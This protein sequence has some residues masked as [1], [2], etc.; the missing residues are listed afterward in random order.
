MKIAIVL[1]TSW[2]IYNFRKGLIKNFLEQGHEVVAIAPKDQFS[3][4][5]RELP[6]QFIPIRMDSRGIN[7]LKDIGL[8]FELLWI[9]YRHA[10]D[11]ILHYTIKPN[12]FGSIAAGLLGIKNVANV[13]GLGTLFLNPGLPTSFAMWLY[14]LAFRFPF[15]VFFQNAEDQNVFVSKNLI[16]ESRCRQIPGSG[17]DVDFFR[18]F[19]KTIQ[20]EVHFLMM[21]R[22]ILDKGVKEFLSAARSLKDKGYN[23]RFSL[24]GKLDPYHKRGIPMAKFAEWLDWSGVNYLG[25][26]ED[27]RH[28]ISTSDVVVLPSYREGTPKSLLE[29]AACGKPII[30]TNVPGCKQVVQKGY[31]GFLCQPGSA[32]D[33]ERAMKQFYDLELPER[34]Q[35]GRNSRKVAETKFSERIVIGIY[36]EIIQEL[37]LPAP[38]FSEPQ[39]QRI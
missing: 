13:C 21:S 14:K 16:V 15:K 28:L 4:R 32:A 18:P 22:I 1:N 26:K 29:A 10:P 33:L 27:I 24:A 6:C 19:L 25:F 38:E 9:Y 36:N 17:V 34:R 35:M 7:P 39:M 2:N 37:D 5:I 8:F 23:V 31:N 30:C 3:D 20:S 11:L 12:I